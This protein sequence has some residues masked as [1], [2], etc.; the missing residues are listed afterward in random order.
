MSRVFLQKR[1]K[2]LRSIAARSLYP[3]PEGV[4]FTPHFYNAVHSDRYAAA[5]QLAKT[6]AHMGRKT[7]L[8][9]I[10]LPS[11]TPAC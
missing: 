7:V 8:I 2:T 10:V 6:A 3:T 11:R 5:T 1:Q 4:G 9:S